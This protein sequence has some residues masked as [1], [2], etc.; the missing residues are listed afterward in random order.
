VLKNNK[1]LTALAF[2]SPLLLSILSLCV[3]VNANFVPYPVGT[4][5]E[6]PTI[7]LTSPN[8]N[9][10]YTSKVTLTFSVITPGSWTPAT[11]QGGTINAG[12]IDNIT[13]CIDNKETI[14]YTAHLTN[15]YDELPKT[16]QF[17]V[18]L[19]NLATGSHHLTVTVNGQ[20]T[21]YLDAQDPWSLTTTP[22][23]VSQN[24]TFTVAQSMSPSQ[25]VPEFLLWVAFS[26]IIVVTGML[27]VVKRKQ[28]P[29]DQLKQH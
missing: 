4:I 17:T 11:W 18:I 26:L 19:E 6:T 9:V 8:Q 12:T 3:P 28:R 13:Y 16:H 7:T 22:I 21:Y 20:T 10:T 2:L 24:T 25:A 14:L 27:Y 23:S 29:T 1:A 15:L 5:T